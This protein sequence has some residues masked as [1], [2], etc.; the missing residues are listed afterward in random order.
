VPER[1]LADAREAERELAAGR[2]RGP[3]HG[4]PI[5]LKDLVAT[6]GIPT[7]A[8]SRVLDGWVPERTATVARRLEEA[9]TVLLGKATTHEF[10]F[11]VYTPPTRNPWDLARIPGGSSGGSAAALA[12]GLCLGAIGTDTAGSIRIPAALCGVSGLKPTHGR[13]SRAGVV[14]FSWSLDHVGPMARTAADLALLL[15]AIAGAD[16]DDPTSAAEP[17]PDYAAALTGD[18]RG[19][20][21]GVPEEFFWEH[22]D[23]AAAAAARSAVDELEGL[24]AVVRPVRLPLVHLTPS[25]GDAI[26]F[27]EVSLYHRR[28]IAERAAEYEPETLANLRLG[29]LFLATDYLQAQ[30]VRRLVTEELLAVLRDVDAVVAPTTPVAAIRADERTVRFADGYEESALYAY[31]RL[32]Y[33]ANV[34]GLP[35]LSVPCGATAA[36]L[37]LGLQLVGRPFDEGLLLA[38]GDAYQRATGWHTRTPRLPR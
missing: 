10:A 7:A 36:G 20:R 29:G 13:V 5:A 8:G 38:L 28:W 25:A 18:V 11:D 31:C 9:G 22:V 4:I 27:P 15:Q 33:P 23:A 19:L 32:T 3:L 1:A 14:P 6:A 34:T 12:A 17:V 37:P 21:L 2:S 30:R 16:P 24:G 35:A 26:S